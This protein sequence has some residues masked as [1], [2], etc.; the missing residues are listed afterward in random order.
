MVAM[1]PQIAGPPDQLLRWLTKGV[2]YICM[3]SCSELHTLQDPF[4]A[5]GAR[6]L[7]CAKNPFTLGRAD[8]QRQYE[9]TLCG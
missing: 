8:D 1:D 4:R 2:V 7:I 3:S 5:T 6:F 9:F